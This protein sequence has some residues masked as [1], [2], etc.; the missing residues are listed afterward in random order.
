MDRKK[1]FRK[2]NNRPSGSYRPYNRDA[3]SQQRDF[4]P[5]PG[6]VDP[7]DRQYPRNESIMHD[8]MRVIDENGE[9][10][11]II[12]K[13]EA[14]GIAKERELDLVLYA[15][16]AN[17]VVCK[18]VEWDSFKYNIKKK[19]KEIRK[20]Q[21]KV[22]LKEIKLTPKIAGTDLQRKLDKVKEIVTE[23]DQVKI[24]IM[25]KFPVTPEQA[26]NFKNDLLTKIDDY[27]TIISV[28]EKGKNIFILVKL[29]VATNAKTEN[30]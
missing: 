13:I 17:P 30:K 6:V 4:R 18:I 14:L 23:G 19:E 24:T 22:K 1:P 12:T 2:F 29:K 21:K 5:R 26:T 11:G 28:Q 16:Q 25:R 15:A 20:H 27:C 9:N 7:F 10:L 8:Q 3:N